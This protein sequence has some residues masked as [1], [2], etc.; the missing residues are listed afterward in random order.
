MTS[1][2]HLIPVHMR[3]RASELSWIYRCEIVCLHRLPSSIVSDH[4]SKFTSRWWLELHRMLGT[5][6]LMSTSYHPQTDDQTEC[7]N[8]D[9]SQILCTVVQSDKKDWIDRV[10]LTEFAINTSVLGTT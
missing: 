6:L 7:M 1:M 3:I 4:D 5:K 8:C 10:N 2:V 9:V